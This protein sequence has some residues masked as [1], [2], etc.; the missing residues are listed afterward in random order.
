MFVSCNIVAPW[1]SFR[2]CPNPNGVSSSSWGY[3]TQKREM[4]S[5]PGSWIHPQHSPA[6]TAFSLVLRFSS[7]F[8]LSLSPH[9]LT[10]SLPPSVSVT[11]INVSQNVP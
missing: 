2:F 1:F 3:T 8:S 10:H 9:L 6:L 4:D 5:V 11:E 7:F